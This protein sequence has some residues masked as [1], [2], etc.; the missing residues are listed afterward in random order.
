MAQKD[1]PTDNTAKSAIPNLNPSAFLEMGTKRVEDM[2][3]IQVE[4]FNALQKINQ[5]WADR[6][7]T[8]ADLASEFVTKLTAMRSIPDAITVSQELAN[9][10]MEMLAEDG[11][12]LMSDG[13]KVMEVGARFLSNGWASNGT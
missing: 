4:L 2:M 5:G 13:Q 7:K 1:P 9:R 10:R 6:A 8:E 11:R 3:K 12:H